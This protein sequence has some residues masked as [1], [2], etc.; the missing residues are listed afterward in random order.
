MSSFSKSE[1]MSKSSDSE[2]VKSKSKSTGLKSKSKYQKTGLESDSSSSPNS[3][4]LH[5][6]PTVQQKN[7]FMIA[8][9]VKI[10]QVQCALW[11][12]VSINVST[13]YKTKIE[14]KAG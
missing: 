5:L 4:I 10:A 2:I 7:D 13:R 3:S 11:P 8:T 6:C 9:L 12:T 14:T 1:S